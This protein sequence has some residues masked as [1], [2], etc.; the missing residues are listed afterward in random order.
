M[1]RLLL[2]LGCGHKKWPGFVNVDGYESDRAKPDLVHDLT[3]PL[4]FDDGVADEIHAYHVIEHFH[5]WEVP[6]IL[7]DWA[8]VLKPGGL[9]VLECPCLNK[10]LGIF[11]HF[12]AK[13]QAVDGRLTMWA[14]YGDP[15]YKEP[16]MCH[17]WCYS[18]AE[19]TDEMEAVGLTVESTTP[20][21]H[22]P[23]RDMRLEGRK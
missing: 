18:T 15:N 16:A 3:K 9:M 19:L 21:T 12:I 5:R 13:N 23:F 6:V 22:V 11:N 1:E 20:Q 10:V 7:K 2:N 4:P 8:R 17:R 14:L